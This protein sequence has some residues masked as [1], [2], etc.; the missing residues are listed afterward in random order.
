[1]S[2]EVVIYPTSYDSVRLSLFLFALYGIFTSLVGVLSPALLQKILG[3]AL[4]LIESA[5]GL[6]SFPAPRRGFV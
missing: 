3:P 6:V 1:M 4:Q 2:T 5:T